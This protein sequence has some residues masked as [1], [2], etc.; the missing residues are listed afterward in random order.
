[1]AKEKWCLG[2]LTLGS[3]LPL[4]VIEVCDRSRAMSTKGKTK[5]KDTFIDISGTRCFKNLKN[6]DA[7]FT[8]KLVSK[9][10]VYSWHEGSKEDNVFVLD[11]AGF[12]P[13]EN[14]IPHLAQVQGNKYCKVDMELCRADIL[15]VKLPT[16]SK[17]RRANE[18]ERNEQRKDI[19]G[20]ATTAIQE[21]RK[22]SED[23][24]AE[25]RN[26]AY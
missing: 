22:T 15:E 9:G 25:K 24:I 19:A 13:H 14:C 7:D 10:G 17:Q 5:T 18:K 11:K 23:A 6:G 1:M 12:V 16:T 4:D 20:E 21:S 8:T 2:N 26:R 3:K